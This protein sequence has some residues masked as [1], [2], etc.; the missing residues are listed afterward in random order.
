MGSKRRISKHILPIILKDRRENQVYVEPFVG[1]CNMIDKVKGKRIGNDINKYLI[2][3]WK[4]IQNGYIPP[5]HITKEEYCKIKENKEDDCILTLWAGVCCS[6]C[7]K[8]FGGYMNDY[9]KGRVLKNGILPNYQIE[10][11]NSI[12]KQKD[13]IHDIIFL[14]LEYDKIDYPDN[15]LIYCDPPYESTTKYKDDFNH[16]IFWEWC[17]KISKEG[18]T[19]FVSEYNAPEDF[20]CL[21]EIKTNTQISNGAKGG[22]MLKIE[23]LFTYKLNS[24]KAVKTCATKHVIPPKSKDSG[25]LPKFT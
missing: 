4:A 7:G 20:K 18:H 9:P 8:W 13:K 6:Y 2:M 16:K 1:G 10:R 11:R 12:L 17:R 24:E 15:S 14:N 3:F 25:I 19:V 23:K 5:K 22:N 21:I